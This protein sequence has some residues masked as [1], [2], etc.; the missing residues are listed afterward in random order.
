MPKISAYFISII[1]FAVT[2]SVHAQDT[3]KFPLKIKAGFDIA[4][5]VNYFI[6]KNTLSIEGFASFDLSEKFAPVIEAGYS[7]FKY[8][9]YNYDYSSNGAF[10]RLG[11][12]INSIKPD[13][14]MGKYFAGLGLRYGLSVFSSEVPSFKHDNYWGSSTG[15]VP[16]SLYWGH[17]LEFSPGIRTELFKNVNIGWA[18]KFRLRIYT[19]TGKDKRP[20]YFPGFGNGTGSFSTGINYY[21]IWTI[22]YKVKTVIIK[23]E[24]PEPE[25]TKDQ[26]TIKNFN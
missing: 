8:S 19:T 3:V 4:G 12:D 23:K 6:D 24:V 22:P 9:Q 21:M 5:P 10:I 14:A 13:L 18:I 15:L 11:I 26:T 7:K 25:E 20:V 1:I 16:S 17:F 2:F